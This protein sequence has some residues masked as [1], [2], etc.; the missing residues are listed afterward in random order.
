MVSRNMK[1]NN[2]SACTA[3]KLSLFQM[4]D[5]IREKAP[6]LVLAVL[7]LLLLFGVC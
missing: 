7:S 2:A 6:K 1:E 3:G 4:T 5:P